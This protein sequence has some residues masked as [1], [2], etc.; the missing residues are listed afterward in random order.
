MMGSLRKG[1]EAATGVIV[2]RPLAR[3]KLVD[4]ALVIGAAV[5]VLASVSVGLVAELASEVVA[6]MAEALGIGLVIEGKPIALVLAFLLWVV[7][8]LLLFRSVPAAGLRCR[9]RWRRS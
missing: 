5:F 1:L 3:A 6:R 2:G 8:S 9:T 4:F 7:T